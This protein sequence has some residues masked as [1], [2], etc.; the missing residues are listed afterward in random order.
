MEGGLPTLLEDVPPETCQMSIMHGMLILATLLE[1]VLTAGALAI[2]LVEGDQL[3]ALH[4]V[5]T[6]V[7]RIFFLW[8]YLRQL[9]YETPVSSVK[10]LHDHI[11]DGCHTIQNTQG[12]FTRVQQSIM[13]SAH[14][15]ATLNTFSGVQI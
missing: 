13:R 9:V 1:T 3:R 2:G 12:I 14:R 7:L 11:V 5:W 15:E 10:I 6:S 4:A 8:G